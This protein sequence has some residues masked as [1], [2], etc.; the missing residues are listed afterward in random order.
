MFY[1]KFLY[2][3][4]MLPSILLFIL[5]FPAVGSMIGFNNLGA[6]VQTQ[7]NNLS[8]EADVGLQLVDP[9]TM[10]IS[11]RGLKATGAVAILED[12]DPWGYNDVETILLSYPHMVVDTIPSAS[13]GTSLGKYQ[14]VIISSDQTGA[15]YTTLASYTNWLENYVMGGGT[16]EVHA[17]RQYA[18][19]D[20]ILPGGFGHIVNGTEN[21]DI[22][23]PDHYLLHNPLTITEAELEGWNDS[24]HGYLNNTE[25]SSVILTDGAGEPVL[26]ETRYGAGYILATTQPVEWGYGNGFSDFLENMVW[27]IPTHESPP[28]GALIGPVAILQNTNPWSYDSIQQILTTLGITYDIIA[29]ADF[30]TTDLSP[31]QKVIIASSQAAAFYTAVTTHRTWL[32]D[33]MNAGGILE[34]HAATQGADWILPGGAGFN[35]NVT[36]GVDILTPFHPTLYHPYLVREPELEYWGYSTHGYFNDTTGA[37]LILDD[38]VE[39][40]FFENASGDGFMI[41]TGQ[42]VEW[43]WWVDKNYSMFLENLIRYI[44]HYQVHLQPGD[45]IDTVWDTSIGNYYE[46][47]FTCG[48]YLDNWRIN[49]TKSVQRFHSDHTMYDDDLYW[50]SLQTNTRV[51]DSGTSWWIGSSFIKMIPDAG[52]TIG[53][54]IPMWNGYGIVLGEV[55]YLWINGITY[56]CWNVSWMDGIYLTHSYFEKS[57]GVLLYSTNLDYDVTTVATNLVPQPPIVIVTYPNGGETVNHT[58]T[59]TWNAID[60]NDDTMTFDVDF[61]DGSMWTSLVSGLT[62]TSYLWDTTTVPNGAN[63]RVRLTAH[64][65]IF[66]TE[67]ESNAVFTI[68]NP[69]LLPIPLP[70]WWWIAALVVVIII[71]VII[72]IYLLMK[73]RGVSK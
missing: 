2:R 68:D 11:S 35:Y 54:I 56:E 73:R 40:I 34:V 39:P 55:D 42:T 15:F 50:L 48:S 26:I 65:G 1:V 71:V 72:V 47:N 32:E 59:I 38:G 67:D 58:I 64:D 17:A 33:Y 52:L 44:P 31:Y 16:L 24:A 12:A 18:L 45:Y 61:W 51:F 60:P 25:S 19:G 36:D 10:P 53:S 13:F 37:T 28:D 29:S 6:S 66:T 22:T 20:W 23:D 49:M 7:T 57:S 69:P 4:W 30:G 3:K 8:A 27:Y 62:T 21:V 14:K 70:W 63:Y 5:L 41:A 43:A 46:F 9:P